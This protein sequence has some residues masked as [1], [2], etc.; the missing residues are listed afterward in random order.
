[1]RRW[2]IIVF[3]AVLAVG[4]LLH[5]LP[6]YAGVPYVHSGQH[7]TIT[8]MHETPGN[9]QPGPSHD[10][11]ATGC[12]IGGCGFCSAEPIAALI[13]PNW[14]RVVRPALAALA[15]SREIVPPLRPPI[16]HA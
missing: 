1:M 12:A 8:A 7:E 6:V 5:P 2:V 9:H 16:L 13:V 10:V 14:V 15:L 11:Q 3:A 4:S